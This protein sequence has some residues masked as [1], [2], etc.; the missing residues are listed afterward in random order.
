MSKITDPTALGYVLVLLNELVQG[1]DLLTYRL[2]VNLF[3]VPALND[4]YA[5]E[6]LIEVFTGSQTDI[7]SVIR[8][9][10]RLIESE[11]MSD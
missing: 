1:Y 3:G 11:D 6:L 7:P 5:R 8:Y 4:P 10:E 9:L 2:R